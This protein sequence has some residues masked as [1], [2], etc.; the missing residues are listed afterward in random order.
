MKVHYDFLENEIIFS[1]RE[2]NGESLCAALTKTESRAYVAHV[3]I[4]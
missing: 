2:L 3:I 4:T 1:I